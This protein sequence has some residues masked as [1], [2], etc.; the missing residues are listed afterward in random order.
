MEKYKSLD[1]L[2]A[3][4]ALLIVAAHTVFEPQY[5]LISDSVSKGIIFFGQL[6]YL[7][8][9]LSAFGMC[10]G[11]YDRFKN[12]STDLNT[13][14]K[15][16]YIRILPFFAILVVIELAYTVAMQHFA[17]N[18][19]TYGAIFESFADLTLA[20]GLL[21][22]AHHISIVGVGW[23]LGLIFVFYMLFPFFVFLINNK[24][25][26]WKVFAICII[27]SWLASTYF[28]SPEWVASPNWR[29]NIIVSSPFFVGGGIL[30]LYRNDIQRCR[31]NK[32]NELLFV[33][34][35]IV[36]T[37]VFFYCQLYSNVILVGIL[38]FLYTLYAIMGNDRQTSILNNP[39]VSYL[40]GIS[41]EI[42]LCHMLFLRV[43]GLIHL[44][45]IIHNTDILT[46]LTYVFVLSLSILFAS[47]YKIIEKRVIH[48]YDIK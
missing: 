7:F 33:A 1:G 9:I 25:R 38:M 6:V 24:R 44:E 18:D 23:F 11:Y 10:C 37:I 4:S 2:R 3:F 12:N 34:S 20:F 15:K 13:F 17:I 45:K 46:L 8:M 22:N 14:Y 35:L 43:V 48:K 5:S 27:M 42:Y 16:R 36:Y 26:S 39:I 29:D 21:P 40:S 47:T 41:F 32:K 30:F 19:I 31:N 28:S